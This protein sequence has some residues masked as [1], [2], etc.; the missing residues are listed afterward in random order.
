MI[1]KSWVQIPPDAALFTL[2][3]R[4]LSLGIVN[5]EVGL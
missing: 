4:P 1:K 3:F 2:F 5:L